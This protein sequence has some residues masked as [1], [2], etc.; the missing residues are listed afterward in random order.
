MCP[1]FR[2]SKW[3]NSKENDISATQLHYFFI[4]VPTISSRWQ[5]HSDPGIFMT[6]RSVYLAWNVLGEI[7]VWGE[8]ELTGVPGP[9]I[10]YLNVS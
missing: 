5:H 10:H 6:R 2:Q 7:T 1:T 3:F 8:L 4:P 9:V